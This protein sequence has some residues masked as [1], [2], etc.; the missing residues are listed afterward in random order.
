MIYTSK[1]NGLDFTANLNRKADNVNFDNQRLL[2]FIPKADIKYLSFE[3][4]FV[5]GITTAKLRT[6]CESYKTEQTATYAKLTENGTRALFYF[7]INGQDLVEDELVFF[8]VEYGTSV[9]YS[10]IYKVKSTDFFDEHNILEVNG[11]NNDE[12]HGYLTN[13]AFGFFEISMLK[14]DIFLAKT[15]NYEYSYSRKL[16]LSS[17]NQIGKRFI[18]SNLTMHKANL[19]K[20]LTKCENFTIDGKEYQI[21]SDF[22]ELEADP[23]SEVMSLQAD[24]VEV[25]Q[26]FFSS[27]ATVAPTELYGT[28]IFN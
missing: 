9:G 16:T 12:R 19:I 14:S 22:T 15:V 25:E 7:E 20:W 28:N 3:A 24:F 13:K 5:S 26:S 1:Y 11:W 6:I 23:H 4:D 17:E 8:R 18:F 21:V 27:A 10:E 2:D